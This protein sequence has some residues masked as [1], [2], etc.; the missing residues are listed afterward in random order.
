MISCSSQTKKV[1]N[2][3]REN[4]TKINTDQCNSLIKANSDKDYL[5]YGRIIFSPILL[6]I[7]GGTFMVPVISA[8]VGIDVE[9]RIAASKL[10]KKCNIKG[11]I[12]SNSDI[13]NDV[14][15]GATMGII[16]SNTSG[17]ESFSL[18][19]FKFY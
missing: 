13:T 18:P 10:A 9:D 2:L 1:A 7:S 11:H 3:A 12:K 6:A 14:L 16:S 4:S 15:K 17:F 5:K 19:Q 8:N